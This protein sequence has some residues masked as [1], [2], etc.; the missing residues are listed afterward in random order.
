MINLIGK[1]NK[2]NYTL[3]NNSEFSGYEVYLASSDDYQY[4]PIMMKHLNISSVHQPR[5][6]FDLSHM[7][8]LGDKSY[9]NMQDLVTVLNSAGFKGT[10]VIHGNYIN[11]Y[12]SD[13]TEHIKLLAKR[14]NSLKGELGDSIKV[15]F[16]T[17]I[18]YFNL[19]GSN[20]SLL[21]SPEDF[22]MLGSY[23]EFPLNIVLD[24]E[25]IYVT[26]VFND[27]IKSHPQFYQE[28]FNLKDMESQEKKTLKKFWSEYIS[29]MGDK[30]DTLVKRSLD[31]FAELKS[32]I[33]FFHINGTK[34]DAYW[35]DEKNFLPLAG[36]HLCLGEADDKL[37]YPML[38]EYLP[39]LTDGRPI[40]LVLEIWPRGASHEVYHQES[41]NSANHLKKVLC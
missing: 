36:E 5:K 20:R 22:R 19:I 24:F 25:H 28:I 33:L 4:L 30:V 11:E 39:K 37:N 16:E 8:E 26:A 34:P 29:K 1:V 17:D 2:D 40:N 14:V 13:K 12:I 27:F 35:F 38:K 10:I 23:L 18:A 6:D 41:I 21:V 31:E 9:K 15:A 3:F 7:G 32:N